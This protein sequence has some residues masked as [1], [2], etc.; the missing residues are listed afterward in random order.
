M[1]G[2]GGGSDRQCIRPVRALDS[3][4]FHLRQLGPYRLHTD[5]PPPPSFFLFLFCFHSV[6]VVVVVVVVVV[7]MMVL[8]LVVVVVV[9][10][11]VV[12]VVPERLCWWLRLNNA[13]CAFEL[14]Y[15]DFRVRSF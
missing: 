11:L 7:V 14:F 8:V 15:R 1:G 5:R 10:V 13:W 6:E 4:N 9:V 2:G 12:V 3:S